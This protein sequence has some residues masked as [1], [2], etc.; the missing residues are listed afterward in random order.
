LFIDSDRSSSQSDVISNEDR[1]QVVGETLSIFRITNGKF[2]QLQ[3]TE[4]T[5]DDDGNEL[6]TPEYDDDWVTA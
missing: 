2:E 6:D 3:V 1:E 5:E 4:I